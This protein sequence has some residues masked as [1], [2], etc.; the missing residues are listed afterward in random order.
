[1]AA[2]LMLI[3]CIV[4][5]ALMSKEV[6]GQQQDFV[7]LNGISVSKYLNRSWDLGASTQAMFN[8]NV[9]EL[10]IAFGDVSIGYKT[11]YNINVE[12]H[13]RHILFRNLDNTMERRN[14]LYNTIS[15][16][17]GFGRFTFMARNRLQQLV[18]GEFFDDNIRTPRWYN[19]TRFSIR[20]K[21]NYYI[22]PFLSAELFQPLNHPVRN[23][24]DQYRVAAGI[25]YQYSETLRFETFYQL[26]QQR[27]RDGNNSNFVFG[28]N[29][30]I[31]IP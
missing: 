22:S 29:A 23:G 8:Q 27:L 4:H 10:W 19:R 12:M 2:R 30:Q 20:Y 15:W 11:K 31:K 14:M 24:L 21:I 17:E 25:T 13:Y 28:I 9:S 26:Q 5:A 7:L 18:Y 6:R 3:I 1:M 16:Y